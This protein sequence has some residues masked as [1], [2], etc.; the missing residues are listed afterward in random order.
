MTASQM[1][2]RR[3]PGVHRPGIAVTLPTFGGPVVVCDVGAN[4]DPK[5][6]HLW[7]YAIM[8][9]IYC[10]ELLGIEDPK[11]ALLNFGGEEAKGTEIVKL[12]RDLLLDTPDLNYVGYIEG[13]DMFE[14]AAD[15]VVTD[16]FVGN[17]VIKLSEGL[18]AGLFQ[19]IAREILDTAP[20]LAARFEPVIKS[21]YARHD[22][23][24]FG[25]APLLGINGNCLICHGSSEARTI[26]STVKKALSMVN[27]GLNDAIVEKLAA[28]SKV[29]VA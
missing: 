22:Y 4:P 11:V 1:Y 27:Q 5:A 21:I 15:V 26:Y 6:H 28:T 29:G 8:A 16:G 20:D 14:H 18:A 3:L 7:Q 17:V 2:L 25:G 23:H 19:T 12:T 13:R 10:R 24:E 9:E